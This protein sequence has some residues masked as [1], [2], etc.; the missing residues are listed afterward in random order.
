ML[1]ASKLTCNIETKCQLLVS[2]LKCMLNLLFDKYTLVYFDQSVISTLKISYEQLDWFDWFDSL[3]TT[4]WMVVSF[5]VKRK[6]NFLIDWFLAVTFQSIC[7]GYFMIYFFKSD[8]LKA[9]QQNTKNCF[10]II[11]FHLCKFESNIVA[12]CFV[13]FSSFFREWA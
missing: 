11:I 8:D 4:P 10:Q 9:W 2:L 1:L 6:H 7:L 12:L 13:W 3:G 5:L